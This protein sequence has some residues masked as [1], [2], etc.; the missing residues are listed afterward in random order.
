MQSRRA[1]TLGG[2]VGAALLALL[3][4]RVLDDDCNGPRCGSR[5]SANPTVA[6]ATTETST[7]SDASVGA[8]LDQ[9]EEILRQLD[10]ELPGTTSA[11]ERELI[12]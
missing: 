3:G 7:T 2:A 4:F 11:E 8:A 12:G 6:S 1:L 10:A 5:A 9:V